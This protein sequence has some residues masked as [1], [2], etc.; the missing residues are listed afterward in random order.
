[1]YAHTPRGEVHAN[2]GRRGLDESVGALEESLLEVREAKGGDDGIAL[3]REAVADIIDRR[4][5]RDEPGRGP[6]VASRNL[7]DCVGEGSE[8]ERAGR[9]CLPF[10]LE[11]FGLDISLVFLPCMLAPIP[12]SSASLG[13]ASIIMLHNGRHVPGMLRLD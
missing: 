3:V 13:Y 2:E 9:R 4:E 7:W 5:E 11:V 1:M 8:R 12:S 10:R 6:S